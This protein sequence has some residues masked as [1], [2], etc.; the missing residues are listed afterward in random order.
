[1]VLR[2]RVVCPADPHGIVGKSHSLYTYWWEHGGGDIWDRGGPKVPSDLSP[3][4][5][6]SQADPGRAV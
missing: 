3:P 6:E 4:Y 2:D 1:M 5:M